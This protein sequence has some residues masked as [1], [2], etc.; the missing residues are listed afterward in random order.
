M[1]AVKPPQ[2]IPEETRREIFLALVAAQ[3]K[4]VP[5]RHSRD[6]VASQFGVSYQQVKAIEEE[7]L[8]N[9]WPPL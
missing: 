6:K 5:V 4:K 2:P 8:D 7:G 9:D 3:D 1:P